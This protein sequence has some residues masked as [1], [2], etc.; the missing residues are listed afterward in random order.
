MSR[1]KKPYISWPI[2]RKAGAIDPQKKTLGRTYRWI[3]LSIEKP[4]SKIPMID[5]YGVVVFVQLYA[6]VCSFYLPLVVMVVLYF[7]I[8]STA[9][10][11]INKVLGVIARPLF[12]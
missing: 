10:D 11:I 9:R 2:R 6:T 8:Y 4:R 1:L 7:R 12:I 3:K 5:F